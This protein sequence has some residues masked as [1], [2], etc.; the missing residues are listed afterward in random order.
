MPRARAD[1]GL[2]KTKQKVIK[3]PYNKL[4]T[5]RASSSHTGEYWPSVIFV[6]TSL[7]SVRTATT[8][9]QYS[10]LR[11]LCSVSKKLVSNTCMYPNYIQSVLQFNYKSIDTCDFTAD[12][13]LVDVRGKFII[14]N[15]TGK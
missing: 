6:Q 10:P 12:F 1:Y 8:P 4:R 11:P 14:Q 15:V 9:G 7:R 3:K 2:A 13:L 5:N